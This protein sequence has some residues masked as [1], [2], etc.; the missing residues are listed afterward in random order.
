[1]LF[2]EKSKLALLRTPKTA[3]HK[4]DADSDDSKCN[5]SPKMSFWRSPDLSVGIEKLF[6]LIKLNENSKF[7]IILMDLG[8]LRK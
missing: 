8:N 5:S 7:L 6:K 4:N 1:L 2:S 3:N